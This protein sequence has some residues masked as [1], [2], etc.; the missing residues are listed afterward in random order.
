MAVVVAGVV[1]GVQPVVWD[2]ESI[3]VATPDYYPRPT[4][5]FSF[6]FAYEEVHGLSLVSAHQ[7]PRV[8]VAHL[9]HV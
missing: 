2:A 4:A 9:V 8:E 1:A 3:A 5:C 6:V 7:P